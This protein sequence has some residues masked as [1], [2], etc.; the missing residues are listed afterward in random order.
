MGAAVWGRLLAGGLR[1][2][3]P[4]FSQL[5]NILHY[6]YI[7]IQ[8]TFTIHSIIFCLFLFINDGGGKN[9]VT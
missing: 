4:G 3:H 5:G 1:I 7:Q 2:S 9:R 6:F 8:V